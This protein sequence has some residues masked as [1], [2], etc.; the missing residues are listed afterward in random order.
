M[1]ISMF[2][3][4]GVLLFVPCMYGIS[5]FWYFVISKKRGIYLIE[6]LVSLA[7]LI[8]IITLAS[9]AYSADMGDAL[10]AIFGSLFLIPV[11]VG[12]LVAALLV[13]LTIVFLI[14]DKSKG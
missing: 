7:S 2:I 14:K 10:A 6:V 11:L 9:I 13:K 12:A 3:L 8:A 5:M 4:V 1:D